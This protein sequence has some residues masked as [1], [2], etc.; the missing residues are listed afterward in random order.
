MSGSKHDLK[1]ISKLSEQLQKI[2]NK[3][4]ELFLKA[5]LMYER[6]IQD[7]K[8]LSQIIDNYYSKDISLFNEEIFI[9]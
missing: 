8:E 9:D 1:E 7:E 2:G 4:H 3:D 5:L 6:N